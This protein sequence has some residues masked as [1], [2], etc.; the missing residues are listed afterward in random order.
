VDVARDAN[1]NNAKI[2][3]DAARAHVLREVDASEVKRKH[4]RVRE[5]AIRDG[6]EK[7]ADTAGENR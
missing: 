1:A 3:K 2:I 6:L 5:L 7:T 4:V